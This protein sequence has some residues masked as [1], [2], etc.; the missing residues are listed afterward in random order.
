MGLFLLCDTLPP[1]VGLGILLIS[2][3]TSEEPVPA[4]QGVQAV[5]GWT[6]GLGEDFLF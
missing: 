6:G 4:V 3:A 5:E 2:F 1:T